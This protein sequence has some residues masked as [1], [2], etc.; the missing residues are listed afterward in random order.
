MRPSLGVDFEEKLTA[1]YP[2]ERA[3]LPINRK[4]DGTMYNRQRIEVVE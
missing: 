1:E 3:H 2:Y 4:L